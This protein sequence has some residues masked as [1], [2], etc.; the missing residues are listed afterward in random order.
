MN[1]RE[2]LIVV[3]IILFFV[4]ILL[5]WKPKQQI[6]ENMAAVLKECKVDKNPTDSER[7]IY[8]RWPYIEY[9]PECKWRRFDSIRY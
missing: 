8:Q 2:L 5:R 7:D 6:K 3:I 9:E 1:I 4:S